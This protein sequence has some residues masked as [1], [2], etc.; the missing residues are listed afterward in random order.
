M[1]LHG[2]NDQRQYSLLVFLTGFFQREKNPVIEMIK[3]A[4]KQAGCQKESITLIVRVTP[5]TVFKIH[6]GSCSFAD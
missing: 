2:I 3:T 4:A 5:P 1:S 6:V